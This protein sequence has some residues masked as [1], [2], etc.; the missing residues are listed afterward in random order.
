MRVYMYQ[1]ALYC[2][3]CGEK[4]RAELIAK[5]E[6]P[7]DPSDETSYDSDDYPKG[8]LDEGESD[9]PSHCDD[10]GEFL[11]TTLTSD[12]ESYVIE[13]VQR[14]RKGFAQESAGMTTDEADDLRSHSVALTEWE[15]FYD[16]LDFGPDGPQCTVC[17]ERDCDTPDECETKKGE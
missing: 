1:A 15:P 4:I 10:C 5:G 3:A 2:E 12:G 9:P 11:E 14:A 6:A 17:G 8:P 16:Y 7:A 13:A